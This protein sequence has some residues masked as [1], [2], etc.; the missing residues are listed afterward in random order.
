VSAHTDPLGHDMRFLA[1]LVR[2]ALGATGCTDEHEI[3][4]RSVSQAAIEIEG[5]EHE[6]EGHEDPAIGFVV[7]R[8]ECIRKRLELAA[9]GGDLLAIML[10]SDAPLAEAYAE[11]RSRDLAQHAVRLQEVPRG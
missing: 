6:L 7:S 3:L 5:I 4:K 9:E 11:Y 10:R 8:L 1:D 2:S